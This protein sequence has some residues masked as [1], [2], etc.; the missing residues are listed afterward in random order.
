M[1]HMATPKILHLVRQMN[2]TKLVNTLCLRHIFYYSSRHS[3]LLIANPARNPNAARKPSQQEE[4]AH[5]PL[6]G[7]ALTIGAPHQEGSAQEKEEKK[8]FLTIHVNVAKAAKTLHL[9]SIQH[10]NERKTN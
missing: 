1:F 8:T 2:L 3:S 5:G 6:I 9:A 4:P 7:R 10:K